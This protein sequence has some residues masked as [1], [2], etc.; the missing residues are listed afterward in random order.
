[1]PTGTHVVSEGWWSRLHSHPRTATS[2]SNAGKSEPKARTQAEIRRERLAAELRSNLHKRKQQARGRVA[3]AEAVD[4]AGSVATRPAIVLPAVAPVA[5]R[6]RARG[7]RATR[8]HEGS[9]THGPHHRHRRQAAQG[10]I[11]ISGAKNA[12]LPL[13]IASLLTARPADPQERA[14]PRRRQPAGAHPAQP[15]P[16]PHHRRQA[17]RSV[18][19]HGRDLPSVRPRHRRHHRALRAGQPHAREL[20]GAGPAARPLRPGARSRCRAAAPSAR[21]RST[22]T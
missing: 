18:P 9:S 14:E 6:R 15:W 4:K 10:Q 11:P 13:M 3:A 21:A 16:R 2:M 17:R 5:C 8:S 19:A 1:M 22:C 7:N 20:L 12:A